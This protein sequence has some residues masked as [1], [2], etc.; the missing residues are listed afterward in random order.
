MEQLQ[1]S[2]RKTPYSFVVLTY[3]D[4]MH[5]DRLINSVR[6]LD[7]EVFILDS[8]STDHTLEICKEHSINVRYHAFENHPKQWDHALTTFNISTPWVVALDADQIVTP[9]LFALLRDFDDQAH[10]DVDGIYF[11]RKNFHRGHWIK[12]G[13]YFPFY[14]LKMFRTD[15]GKSDLNENMDH[16]FIVPG[17]IKVWKKGFLVE[18]NLKESQ[19]QF[20]LDKHNRYSDQLA[21]EEVE[22]MQHLRCQTTRPRFWGSPNERKAFFKNIWWKLPRYLRPAI[23]FTYRITLQGGFLDGKTG[24]IFHFLQGFWFRLIVDIKIEELLNEQK[25]TARD[26]IK[27]M[28]PLCIK[29]VKV[30]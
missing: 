15:K 26:E 19:I 16:R 4:E 30:P 22:R 5:L 28:D 6:G 17:N 7:A 8:G 27:I 3:N 29:Q 11:N 21:H 13:G 12:Y 18:E 20:W 25:I 14:M 24:I 10:R 2:D 9:E 23:Y 1:L